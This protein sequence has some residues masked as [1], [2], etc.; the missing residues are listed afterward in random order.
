MD[1]P[2]QHKKIL[3]N[4]LQEIHELPNL[5]AIPEWRPRNFQIALSPFQEFIAVSPRRGR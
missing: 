2:H 4:A 5:V 1:S 3:Q